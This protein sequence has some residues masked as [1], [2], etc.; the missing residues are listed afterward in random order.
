MYK[1]LTNKNKTT[2]DNHVFV[3]HSNGSQ[4]SSTYGGRDGVNTGSARNIILRPPR[5][6]EHPNSMKRQ[7]KKVKKKN[8]HKSGGGNSRYDELMENSKV[9]PSSSDPAVSLTNAEVAHEIL[10][11]IN[12][13][14]RIT[15]A[16]VSTVS[17]YDGKGAI[18]GDIFS[19]PNPVLS[20]GPTL[21]DYPKKSSSIA[22]KI[23][24]SSSINVQREPILRKSKS[25]TLPIIANSENDSREQST[26]LPHMM[27]SADYDTL[28]S[29]ALT[30]DTILLTAMDG[31][32]EKLQRANQKVASQQVEIRSLTRE[33]KSLKSSVR[34]LQKRSNY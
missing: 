29:T 8:M 1:R 13:A 6:F 12:N 4:E 23:I 3:F 26:V 10:D 20:V 33:N 16:P 24:P 2:N 30:D 27:A 28:A 18:N 22:H 9:V 11:E 17:T 5:V 19:V 32:V 15:F 34:S 14:K 31:T 21:P 7:K 25:I